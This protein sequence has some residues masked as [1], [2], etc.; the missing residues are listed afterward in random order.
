MVVRSLS[1]LDGTYSQTMNYSEIGMVYI[2]GAMNDLEVEVD[3]NK[4]GCTC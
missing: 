2:R 3:Q 1:L 4:G